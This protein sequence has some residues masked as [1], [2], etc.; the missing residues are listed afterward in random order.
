MSPRKP[1]SNQEDGYQYLIENYH[2]PIISEEIF[3]M[4]QKKIKDNRKTRSMEI[5]RQNNYLFGRVTCGNCGSNCHRKNNRTFECKLRRKSKQLCGTS[6]VSE[7]KVF[8]MV[9]EAFKIRYDFSNEKVLLALQRDLERMN[10]ND[11]FEYHRLSYSNKLEAAY[12]FKKLASEERYEEAVRYRE[13]VESEF[14][15]QEELWKQL[16]HDRE[17]RNKSIEWISQITHKEEFLK[18]L[19]IERI[20][21]WVREITLYSSVSCIIH[22][23]DSVETQIGDCIIQ[24]KYEKEQPTTQNNRSEEVMPIMMEINKLAVADNKPK[25]EVLKI[26]NSEYLNEPMFWKL[27]SKGDP[28]LEQ[29][30]KK[31][32]VRK[33]VCAYCRVSTDFAD[34][35]SSYTFQI[36]Y[37]TYFIMKNPEYEFS[38]IYADEGISATQSN[39]RVQFQKMIADAAAGKFDQIITKSISRFARNSASS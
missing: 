18:E 32:K 29:L 25:P 28:I 14:A 17:Y 8:N 2:E 33:R 1:D 13:E 27:R 12:Q 16:E 24:N 35:Q 7:R 26:E 20:R 10:A 22:W 31:P 3:D 39:N 15:L 5:K 19:T 34:Q 4:V 11:H 21:G 30:N 37:Y 36:A 9:R 38:G 23:M 6:S